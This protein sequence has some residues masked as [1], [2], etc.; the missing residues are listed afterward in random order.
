MTSD[1]Q[2]FVRFKEHSVFSGE[3]IQSIITFKNVTS[4]SDNAADHKRQSRGWAVSGAAEHPGSGNLGLQ[5]PRQAAINTHGARKTSKSGH[6]TTASLSI[7]FTGSSNPGSTSWTA[8]PAPHSSTSHKYQKSVSIISL[9][10]PDVGNE[11]T[12]R[13]FFLPRSRPP[14]NHNRSATLQVNSRGNEGGPDGQARCESTM[15]L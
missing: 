3:E 7:P 12:R 14:I 8:S 6:R 11:E 13:G 1:I 2:V 10:S 9:G 5:N 4:T 15:S